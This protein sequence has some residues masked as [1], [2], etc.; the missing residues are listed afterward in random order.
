MNHSLGVTTFRRLPAAPKRPLMLDMRVPHRVS[1]RDFLGG[2][3]VQEVPGMSLVDVCLIRS[4]GSSDE[5]VLRFGVE[6]LDDYL[7]FVAGRCRPNTVLAVA[8]DLRVF[9]AVVAKG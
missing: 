4:R 5:P 3:R 1:R 8:Y 7:E 2:Q 9:F 6:V